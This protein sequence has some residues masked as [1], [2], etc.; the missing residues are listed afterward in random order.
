M[1]G[2][3][4]NMIDIQNKQRKIEFTP[5][6]DKLMRAVVE[7]SLEYEGLKPLSVSV[8]ITDNKNIHKLNKQYRGK[9]SPTDVLSFPLY[10]EDGNLDEDELG[11]I[12][13]SL[14]R[15]TEQAQ[16]FGHSVEREIAFLTAHS[17]LHLIGYD[18]E[19]E[20]DEM[21]KKQED[22]LTSLNISR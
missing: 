20:D 16:E 3:I 14:E 2:M 10:D 11:D 12:V 8:L 18:H 22:I 9:D 15:A 19:V 7:K 17:M 13:I 6:M 4:Y 21:F 5:K 1:K